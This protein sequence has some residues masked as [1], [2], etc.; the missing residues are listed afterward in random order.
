MLK[1]I[2]EKYTLHAITC[3][4]YWQWIDII[5][6]TI[7]LSFLLISAQHK[8][9]AL[10]KPRKN[11]SSTT[12]QHLKKISRRRKKYLNKFIFYKKNLFEAPIHPLQV[13]LSHHAIFSS[14]IKNKTGLQNLVKNAQFHFHWDSISFWTD[15]G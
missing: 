8:A 11:R 5:H 12:K 10:G 6:K 4:Q 13:S 9:V 2:Y 15:D 3:R 14:C 7:F 1:I